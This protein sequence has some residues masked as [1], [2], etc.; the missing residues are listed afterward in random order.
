MRVR[1]VGP[2]MSTFLERVLKPDNSGHLEQ[3]F[4]ILGGYIKHGK[5]TVMEGKVTR[6]VILSVHQGSTNF[7]V[8]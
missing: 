6:V 1:Q 4:S 7:G 2:N 8:Q 5:A 3:N